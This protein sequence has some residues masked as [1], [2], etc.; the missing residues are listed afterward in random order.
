VLLVSGRVTN[1]GGDVVR[2]Y[3]K[4]DDNHNRIA[5][6]FEINGATVLDM[7]PLGDG[8]PDMAIGF[9]GHNILIEAKN[10]SLPKSK[11]QLTDDEEKFHAAWR[12]TIVIIHNELEAQQLMST[13]RRQARLNL[14]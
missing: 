4:K 1:D 3:A 9:L 11:Q 10:G 13:M 2:K 8:A 7:S 6:V 14:I 5:E 12:G